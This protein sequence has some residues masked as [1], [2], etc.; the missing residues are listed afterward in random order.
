MSQ[1]HVAIIG[2]RKYPKESESYIRKL[3]DDLHRRHGDKLIIVS[4]GA[5]GPDS[6]AVS[7]AKRIGVAT[8]VFT[9]RWRDNNGNF[10]KWAG[11]ERNT[12]IV[13]EANIIYAFWDGKSRGTKDSLD[14]CV[15]QQ[16]PAYVI[17]PLGEEYRYKE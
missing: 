12:K 3:V 13:N 2:S 14:K 6:V 7:Y 15:G 17:T 9:P 10:R 5:N 11:F 1:V 16:K 4:G 8:L